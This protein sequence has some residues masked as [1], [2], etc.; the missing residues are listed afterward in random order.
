MFTY[1]FLLNFFQSE[2][3]EFTIQVFIKEKAAKSTDLRLFRL[4]NFHNDW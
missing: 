2:Q 3:N 1:A 4:L